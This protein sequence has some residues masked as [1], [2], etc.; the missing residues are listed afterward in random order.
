METVNREWIIVLGD[1]VPQHDD[2]HLLKSD[3]HPA[4]FRKKSPV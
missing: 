4:I 2:S 1:G 3:C